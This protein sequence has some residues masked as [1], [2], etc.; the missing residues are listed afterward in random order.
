MPR[1]P[2]A[3]K[4]LL[5]EL[6]NVTEVASKPSDPDGFGVYR[7]LELRGEGVQ[8]ILDVIGNDPRFVS[9]DGTTI[10]WVSNRLAD[11]NRTFSISRV[12]KVLHEDDDLGLDEDP[13]P[14]LEER[15]KA[16]KADEIREEFDFDKGVSK[17]D[18]IA[19]VLADPP[20]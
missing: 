18:M 3:A 11:D 7:T 16:M 17:K 5:A 12:S 4:Q 1:I 20:E 15:L 6:G 9:I 19:E 14:T 10:T 2:R 13:E 8:E